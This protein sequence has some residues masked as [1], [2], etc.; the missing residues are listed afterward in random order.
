MLNKFLYDSL[1]AAFGTVLVENEN[2]QAAF[3][4][5]FSRGY[6]YEWRL[7]D[8]GEHG[9]QYRVNCPIC[10][11]RKHHL[12][13]GYMSFARPVVDGVELAQG[14]LFAYCFRRNCMSDPAARQVVEMKIRAGM[15]C[16][17][18]GMQ[19][20]AA[21]N[22]AADPEP[23][24]STSDKVTLTGIRT[25]V[26]SFNW[27]DDSADPRVLE[28]L[29]A[30]GIDRRTAKQFL[31]GWG[32]VRSPRTG[33]ALYDGAPCVVVPVV[34]N[35]ALAGVQTR[36]PDSLLPEGSGMK[37]WIHPAMRK[38]AV[39][40][41]VD[42]ARRLGVAVV[43]EGVFDV[44]KV[45]APGVCCF[46]HTPSLTQATMLAGIDQGLIML[47][48]TDVHEDFDTVREAQARCDQ[49]NANGVFPLGAHTV[50]LPAKDA[51][52]MPRQAVWETIIAQVPEA[53]QDYLLAKVVPKL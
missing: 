41:N 5:D 26:P 17:G 28:Y 20:C 30:R 44:F 33:Q 42:S 13:I 52:E 43:C 2:A 39:V 3:E 11:D 19:S 35:G 15:A 6:A 10:G 51:G 25:W 7:S 1:K 31:L 23:E 47:P 9:E 46:G 53:M 49:W 38:K 29:D 12:Y 22:M 32:E 37:Y 50:V 34:Q 48:D 21:I 45:G 8:S 40:Y 27:I 24:Y 36:C 14:R 18:D 4:R 16:V